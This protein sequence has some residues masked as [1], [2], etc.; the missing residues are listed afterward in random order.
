MSCTQLGGEMKQQRAASRAIKTKQL[1]LVSA[2]SEPVTGSRALKKKTNQTNKTNTH[3]PPPQLCWILILK[4]SQ[5]VSTQPSLD[6]PHLTSVLIVSLKRRVWFISNK[7]FTQGL[8]LL[9]YGMKEKF[10]WC[11]LVNGNEPW[12]LYEEF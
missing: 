10:E 3:T 8:L 2:H 6:L 5:F 1:S 12:E 7:V 11:S 4:K 9:F